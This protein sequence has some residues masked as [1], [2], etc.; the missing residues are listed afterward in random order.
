M[1]YLPAIF[2]FYRCQLCPQK[3]I[4]RIRNFYIIFRLK[5][6]PNGPTFVSPNSPLKL[7]TSSKVH[8]NV[9]HWKIISENWHYRGFEPQAHSSL[10]PIYD[11]TLLFDN[12]PLV[13]GGISLPPKKS[14]TPIFQKRLLFFGHFSPSYT[15]WLGPQ[16][17]PAKGCWDSPFGGGV[18][19]KFLK[20]VNSCNFFIA[21]NWEI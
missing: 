2:Y 1:F 12:F 20:G 3:F 10:A 9:S 4:S 15:L 17:T 11:K 5:N 13:E 8:N 6:N 18:K 16:M 7:I 14:F 19:N 21:K